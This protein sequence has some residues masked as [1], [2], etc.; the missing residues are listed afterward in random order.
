MDKDMESNSVTG[1]LAQLGAVQQGHCLW[2]SLCM[3]EGQLC[4]CSANQHRENKESKTAQTYKVCVCATP[5]EGVHPEL[6]GS[7]PS[8]G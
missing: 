2:G 1:I 3:Q 8:A 5:D 6:R 7:C 4:N